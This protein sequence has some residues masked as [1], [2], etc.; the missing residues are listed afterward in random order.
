MLPLTSSSGAPPAKTSQSPDCERDWLASV[1]NSCSP[2]LQLLA[3]IARSGSFGKTSPASFRTLADADLQAFWDC[4]AG[5]ASRSPSGGG[6]L[7]AL[8][9]ATVALTGS[10]GACLTLNMCEWTATLVPC[11]S[12]GGVC[13]LSDVLETGDVPQRYFLSAKACRG[14]LRRAEKRGKTLPLLL[15]R[16]L[17]AVAGS[18]PTSTATED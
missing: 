3:G 15:A 2:M 14:I 17:E 11:H 8:S 6:D 1:V 18:E 16:A 5:P 10:H 4:S 12:D 9:T 13:S 7:R